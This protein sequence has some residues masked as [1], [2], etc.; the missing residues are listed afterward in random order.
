MIVFII[1][2]IFLL[3]LILSKSNNYDARK[4]LDQQLAD[5]ELI[6]V[7]FPIINNDN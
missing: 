2:L 4:Q 3:G 1:L 7:I 6:S 5:D